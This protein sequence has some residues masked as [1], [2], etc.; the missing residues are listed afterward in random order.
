MGNNDLQ[1][2]I[3][4][5]ENKR[6]SLEKWKEDYIDYL[7]RKPEHVNNPY[8]DPD[9]SKSKNTSFYKALRN[10]LNVRE[11]NMK[12]KLNEKWEYPD[13][14]DEKNGFVID[15]S[16]NNER[17]TSLKS[18]QFG[19]SACG[20]WINSNKKDL[21]CIY[22]YD[23][24]LFVQCDKKEK[25]KR[26]EEVAKWIYYSRTL[27]GSFLWPKDIYDGYNPARGGHL[28][29]GEKYYIE[30]RVDL[31]LLEVFLYYRQEYYP[32][33]WKKTILKSHVEKNKE[34]AERWFGH[35]GSFENYV[36][37]FCF[38]GFVDT[39]NGYYIPKSIINGEPLN[40][41][42]RKNDRLMIG[43][44]PPYENI[45]RKVFNNVVDRIKERSKEMEVKL[46]RLKKN[47]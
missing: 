39:N 11:N 32:E 9:S 24:Y 21:R 17:I 36:D 45:N 35:F 16:C 5:K 20:Y 13:P 25:E 8:N 18:D 15:V 38:K 44:K 4:T 12:E 43:K 31:T 22:P 6:Y 1:T 37:F 41:D 30:D 46:T 2:Y 34:I 26:F 23:I 47:K 14:D 10:F 40:I 42:S 19:F 27:G 29:S 3:L 33:E 7:K 28:F